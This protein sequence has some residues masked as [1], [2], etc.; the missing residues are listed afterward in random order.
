MRTILDVE[1]FP[2]SALFV[3]QQVFLK[4]DTV[5]KVLHGTKDGAAVERCKKRRTNITWCKLATMEGVGEQ[6]EPRGV[7]HHG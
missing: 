2:S 3:D 5:L 7:D 6:E 4:V 1:V